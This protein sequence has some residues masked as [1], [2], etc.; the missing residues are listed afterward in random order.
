MTSEATVTDVEPL[1]PDAFD[2]TTDP[3]ISQNGYLLFYNVYVEYKVFAYSPASAKILSGYTAVRFWPVNIV[4]S[5]RWSWYK[6][7][8]YIYIYIYTHTHTHT[9]IYNMDMPLYNK[10]NNIPHLFNVLF[11]GDYINIA[12][13]HT[14]TNTY[15]YTYTHTY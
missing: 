4:L 10:N 13:T 2:L 11:K 1:T 6:H 12:H 5:Q 14:H 7:F 3:P 9:Y 8:T 15:T